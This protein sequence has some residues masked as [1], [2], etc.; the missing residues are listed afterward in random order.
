MAESPTSRSLQYARNKM[1]FLQIG[2][3]ERWIPGANIR[4]DLW[5]IVDLVGITPDFKFMFIQATA[6]SGHAARRKK[7][8]ESGVIEQINAAGGQFE[9][10]SWGK[11]GPAGKR[12]L[13]TLRR[14][15]L[16]PGVQFGTGGGIEIVSKTWMEQCPK[17][18]P[19]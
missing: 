11:K 2:V 9:I 19:S 7:S 4:K 13:W 1:N 15:W 12:K 10:W 18:G 17:R 14:E 5:G 3:V 6:D 16:A 8:I